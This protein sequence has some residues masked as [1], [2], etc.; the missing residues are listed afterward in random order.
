MAEG[1]IVPADAFYLWKLW[2]EIDIM[3]DAGLIKANQAKKLKKD[4]EKAFEVA[5][6][7]K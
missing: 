1:V 2:Y 7:L 4:L 6:G 3:A 5:I